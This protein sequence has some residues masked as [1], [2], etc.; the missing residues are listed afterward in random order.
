MCNR[1]YVFCKQLRHRLP[2]KVTKC[3]STAYLLEVDTSSQS[4]TEAET[5]LLDFFG[6]KTNISRTKL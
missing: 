6:N 3:L 1:I 2:L 4:P 5:L